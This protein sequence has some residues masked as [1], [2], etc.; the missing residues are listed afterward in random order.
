MP[1]ILTSF[2]PLFAVAAATLVAAWAGL[3]LKGVA[4]VGAP[5]AGLGLTLLLVYLMRRYA[6]RGEATL[7]A[8]LGATAFLIVFTLGGGLLSYLMMSRPAKGSSA[9]AA[10]TSRCGWRWPVAAR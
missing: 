3:A 1:A 4:I 2:R 6:R 9:P 7:A 8:A 5:I 10:A